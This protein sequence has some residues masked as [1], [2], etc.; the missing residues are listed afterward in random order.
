[1][2]DVFHKHKEVKQGRQCRKEAGNPS[3]KRSESNPSLGDGQGESRV[4]SIK[5]K[6]SRS[7]WARGLWEAHFQEGEFK[8][9]RE[10][11][12]IELGKRIQEIEHMYTQDC[13]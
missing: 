8:T 11:F 4:K 7:N 13:Y 10:E 3:L 1:M 12:E 6:R 5:Q 2:G 9:I